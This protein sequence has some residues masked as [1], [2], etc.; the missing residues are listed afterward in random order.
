MTKALNQKEGQDADGMIVINSQDELFT[1]A[2]DPEWDPLDP[3][4]TPL[5][6]MV[7]KDAGQALLSGIK[8]FSDAESRVLG[9]INLD[10]QPKPD[11]LEKLSGMG[12][13][14]RFPIVHATESLIQIYA[15]GY[16]G[17]R[18]VAV[19]NNWSLQLVRHKLG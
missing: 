8:R 11:E 1:M 12:S 7:S 15:E 17:I 3:N 16:W 2:G 6:V 5:S 18:A 4:T 9:R 19:N 10:T 13:P 14:F